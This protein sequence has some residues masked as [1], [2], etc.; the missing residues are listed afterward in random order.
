MAPT[1]LATLIPSSAPA[2]QGQTVRPLAEPLRLRPVNTSEV[3]SV[4]HSLSN[5]KAKDVY[6]INSVLLK[7]NKLALTFPITQ[8]IN[9]SILESTFPDALKIA[10]VTPIFKAGNPLDVNNYR[11]ISILPSLSK[12]AE[13]T[14]ANQVTKYIEDNQ[15]M[16]KMQFGFRHKHST[17]T[18]CCHLVENIKNRLDVGHKVGA[19]FLDLRKAFDTVDHATLL[20]KME[21]FNFSQSTNNWF[22]SFLK[23]RKQCVQINGHKSEQGSCLLGVPQGSILAPLLFSLYINDLPDICPNVSVQM[24][25]DD[26]VILTSAKNTNVISDTLNEAMENISIW[27]RVNRLSLNVKKTMAMLF[28]IKPTPLTLNISVDGE[29]VANVNETK[30]LGITIDSQLKF[31]KHA[32]QLSKKLNLTLAT[33]RHIRDSLSTEAAKTFFSALIL[34][35]IN[36][37]ITTWSH[38]NAHKAINSHY[39]RALKILDK[40]KWKDHHCPILRK[41]D[42]L[43]LDNIALHANLV[44]FYKIQNGLAPE[45]LKELILPPPPPDTGRSTRSKTQGK[46]ALPR[47]KTCFGQDSLAFKGPRCWNSLP[48]AITTCPS[49]R[50]FISDARSYLL[51]KQKCD[52]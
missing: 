40:K 41:Y 45:P 28:S 17:E 36:Y 32:N 22:T 4:T 24:Y 38:S 11:P 9:K 43:S 23:N 39:K 51:S 1:P 25:A 33:F 49:L 30:Y 12:V 8:L 15:L 10:T 46:V 35:R 48:S 13:K 20:R 42:Q 14:I 37:C 26:T 27:L 47:K 16:H 21:K 31:N 2:S 6:G 44:L 34:S 7:R 29:A 52:H 19:V 5:S 50:S 3:Y 18:A